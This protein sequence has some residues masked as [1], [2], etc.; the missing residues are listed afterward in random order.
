MKLYKMRIITTPDIKN[1]G[2]IPS[3]KIY[4]KYTLFYESLK[5]QSPKFIKGEPH[6]D[7]IPTFKPKEDSRH[8]DK[9][10]KKETGVEEMIQYKAGEQ[11]LIYDDVKI[12]FFQGQNGEKKL[13]HFWFH[14]S[15]VDSNGILFINKEMTENAHKDKN[16]KKY[17]RNFQIKV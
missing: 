12:E 15:F 7:H 1:G 10:N 11:V 4:C 2:W 8:R 5:H 3:F 16:C 14:T 6:S 9:K 17:D 13:F